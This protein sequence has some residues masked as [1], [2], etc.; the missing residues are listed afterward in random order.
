MHT[1]VLCWSVVASADRGEHIKQPLAA[2]RWPGL[3]AQLLITP[4]LEQLGGG[5]ATGC[6]T[7]T[8]LTT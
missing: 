1:Y 5:L 8:G 6:K 7:G 3:A 2:A 4:T